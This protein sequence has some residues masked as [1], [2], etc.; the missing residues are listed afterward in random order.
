MGVGSRFDPL[1]Y[2][3]E[4]SGVSAAYRFHGEA[5]WG[6]SL[7]KSLEGALPQSPIISKARAL[8]KN[9]LETEIIDKYFV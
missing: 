4:T 2:C 6:G 8:T 5:G 9:S 1:R 3:F 7:F